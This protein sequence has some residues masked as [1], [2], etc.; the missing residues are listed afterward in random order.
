[1]K[2]MFVIENA[3]LVDINRELILGYKVV[4]Q[5]PDALIACL[6]KLK[7]T[8]WH[9]APRRAECFIMVYGN[10]ITSR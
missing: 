1:M 10:N 8:I 4:Q 9:W 7:E 2:S 3:C 5:E 6:S